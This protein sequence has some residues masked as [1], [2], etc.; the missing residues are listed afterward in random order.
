MATLNEDD[1]EV[2]WAHA[3]KS[4]ESAQTSVTTSVGESTKRPRVK[5]SFFYPSGEQIPEVSLA[6]IRRVGIVPYCRLSCR[7]TYR[8]RKSQHAQADAVFMQGAGK[9]KPTSSFAEIEPAA[10]LADVWF[11]LAIDSQF[12]ELTD[13]GGRRK[14]MGQATESIES[15]ASRELYEESLRIF[16]ARYDQTVVRQ[17]PAIVSGSLCVFFVYIDAPEHF[18][19]PDRLASVFATLRS[20][21]TEG[22][23]NSAKG[24]LPFMENSLMYWLPLHDFVKIAKTRTPRPE[25]VAQDPELS[26]NSAA[27]RRR[28]QQRYRPATPRASPVLMPPWMLATARELDSISQKSPPEANSTEQKH[29]VMYETLRRAISPV[30]LLL[31]AHLE[32]DLKMCAEADAH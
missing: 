28:Q 19:F 8:Q 30:S 24:C 12:G 29:P 32:S 9:C 31:C 11:A 4:T 5:K 25:K 1:A 2:E 14:F 20:V 21:A 16:D 17:S 23:V 15:T 22:P 10:E 3:E 6:A 18:G 13:C 7:E 26:P 27:A